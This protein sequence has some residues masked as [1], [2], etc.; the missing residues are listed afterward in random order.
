MERRADPGS[1]EVLLGLWD[2]VIQDLT[3]IPRGRRY[4][5]FHTELSAG[6]QED[7]LVWNSEL[8]VD[9]MWFIVER[10]H[11]ESAPHTQP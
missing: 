4:G 8:T 9:G 10:A 7:K 3:S 1:P 2:A 11:G 6:N 5:F